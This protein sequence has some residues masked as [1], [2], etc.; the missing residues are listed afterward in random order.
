[1]RQP[2]SV[3]PTDAS[4]VQQFDAP[5]TSTDAGKRVPSA[6]SG[7]ALQ[8]RNTSSGL[9]VV[10]PDG[11]RN[12]RANTLRLQ[13]V[14]CSMDTLRRLLLSKADLAG[15]IKLAEQIELEL[16]IVGAQEGTQE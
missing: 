4:C 11:D 12:G 7:G 16:R 9:F 15:V 10:R 5:V 1:M 6:L 14:I 8:S 3:R 13:A 2:S